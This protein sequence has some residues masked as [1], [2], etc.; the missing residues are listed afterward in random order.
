MS[1]SSEEP[2]T[3]GPTGEASQSLGLAAGSRGPKNA[4]KP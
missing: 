3:E 1:V 4:G 2:E